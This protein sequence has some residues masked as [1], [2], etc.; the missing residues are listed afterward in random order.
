[1]RLRSSWRSRWRHDPLRR[2][3]PG[4]RRMLET[5]ILC[6]L[7]SHPAIPVADRVPLSIEIGERQKAKLQAERLQL[8]KVVITVRSTPA[9]VA[10]AIFDAVP[11]KTFRALDRLL[12]ACRPRIEKAGLDYADVEECL[13]CL[14][15][16]IDPIEV[17]S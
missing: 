9:T 6:A 4:H 1:M 11:H 14:Y 16:W 7:A 8:A 13:A 2:F 5:E 10:E 3:H 15:D 12:Q 17:A